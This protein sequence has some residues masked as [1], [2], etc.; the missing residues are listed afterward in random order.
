MPQTPLTE[1]SVFP[2]APIP[3]P[4]TPLAHFWKQVAPAT[5]ATILA[6][7]AAF[8]ASAS[9]AFPKNT[10]RSWIAD[11]TI[12][13]QW[14]LM[15][16]VCPLPATPDTVAAFLEHQVT[17]AHKKV[18]TVARY[19]ATLTTLHRDAAGLPNPCDARVVKHMM[20][21]LRA[22]D[23]EP[24]KQAAPLRWASIHAALT[25]LGTRP[26]DLLTKALVCVA[27]DTL[28]RRSDLCVLRIQDLE[29]QNDGSATLQMRRVKG[30]HQNPWRKKYLHPTTVGHLHAWLAWL[31]QSD[32][33]LFRGIYKTGGAKPVRLSERISAM[34]VVRAFR[35]VARQ[36][37]L[38]PKT[39]SGHSCRVGCAQDMKAAGIS[40]PKLMSAGDWRSEKMPLHYTEALNEQEGGVAEAAAKLGR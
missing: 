10:Q 11:S 38:D 32:G 19:K 3:V 6:N 17:V 16:G 25:A 20:R 36:A 40:L 26:S 39:I 30:R 14:C 12:F 2:L 22:Q 24:P 13:A 8:Y 31:D 23:A 34:G 28:A 18:T 33:L 1:K 21:A 15:R 4:A 35:R 29:I 7:L 5:D 9:G 37:G 27:Y